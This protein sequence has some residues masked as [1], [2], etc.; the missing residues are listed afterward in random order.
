M[1]L[2]LIK[3]KKSLPPMPQSKT[4]IKGI[5]HIQYHF[6]GR[7]MNAQTATRLQHNIHTYFLKN[8][9]IVKS[10]SVNTYVDS[11]DINIKFTTYD[12]NNKHNMTLYM[13]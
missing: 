10:F 5:T 12:S 9:E 11:T 6:M 2:R 7:N 13:K 4:I 3:T 1:N 8:H